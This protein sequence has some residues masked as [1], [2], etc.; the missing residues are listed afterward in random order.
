ME[1]LSCKLDRALLELIKKLNQ[2]NIIYVDFTKNV[3]YSRYK[4]QV[5]NVIYVDFTKKKAS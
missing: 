1:D 5:D 3:P 2:S 4:D